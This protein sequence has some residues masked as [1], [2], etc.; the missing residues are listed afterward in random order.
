MAEVVQRGWLSFGITV[1]AVLYGIALLAWVAFVPSTDGETLLEYGG[2][3]SVAITVQPLLIS[4]LMWGLMRRRCMTG[5]RAAT[6]ASWAI[7]G[8]YL[9]WSV[10]GALS[11]AAGAFPAAFLLLIAVTLTPA[12]ARSAG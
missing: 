5:S 12:S 3:W 8:L 11:L 6:I 4:L 7:A 9:P 2:P 1:A 10:L